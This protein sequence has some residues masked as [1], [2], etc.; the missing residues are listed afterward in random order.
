MRDAACDGSFSLHLGALAKSIFFLSF[1][2]TSPIQ[3]YKNRQ[4]V[5]KQQI[6]IFKLVL[7]NPKKTATFSPH[8]IQGR[9]FDGK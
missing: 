7:S 3:H 6:Q 5:A 9:Y 4:Q 8:E 1:F 2:A